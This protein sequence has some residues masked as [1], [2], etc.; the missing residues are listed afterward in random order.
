VKEG[1]VGKGL[2]EIRRDE[3]SR[4]F[5]DSLSTHMPGKINFTTM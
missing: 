2:E 4:F 3:V 1:F 5:K